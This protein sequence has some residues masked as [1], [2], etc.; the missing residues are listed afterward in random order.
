MPRATRHNNS[1]LEILSSDL[2]AILL[3]LMT[4]SPVTSIARSVFVLRTPIATSDT[5][6]VLIALKIII[7]MKSACLATL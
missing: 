5:V 1:C 2:E 3:K 6:N 7:V 4:D